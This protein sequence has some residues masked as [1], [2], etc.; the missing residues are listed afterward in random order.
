MSRSKLVQSRRFNDS[1]PSDC[2]K[3][4]GNAESCIGG[5]V[6]HFHFAP[7]RVT[8]PSKERL[9]PSS[10]LF[11]RSEFCQSSICDWV[12][13]LRCGLCAPSHNFRIINA[14][15]FA[16][17]RPRQATS[18]RMRLNSKHQALNLNSH[19]LTVI[20]SKS[21]H[22]LEIFG[23]FNPPAS[24]NDFNNSSAITNSGKARTP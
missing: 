22:T 15:I 18:L 24:V 23:A 11:C 9:S 21:H 19:Y 5:V 7:R 8:P 3:V 6:G 10:L 16:R 20:I 14:P 4:G 13:H 2:K 17:P 12:S 1:K